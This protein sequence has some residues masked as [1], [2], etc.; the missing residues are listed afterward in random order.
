MA[1]GKGIPMSIATRPRRFP[2]PRLA[3][4]PALPAPLPPATIV[5]ARVRGDK[6]VD[7]MVVDDDDSIDWSDIKWTD[8]V[9]PVDDATAAK[10]MV[11]AARWREVQLRPPRPQRSDVK[12]LSE[13]VLEILAMKAA[14]LR[15]CSI[16][17]ITGIDRRQ[18][19]RVIRW[20]FD[21]HGVR[22]QELA[23]LPEKS[24]KGIREFLASRWVGR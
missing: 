24:P 5:T 2:L 18:I 15:V 19:D 3:P 1:H 23:E 4:M 22:M 14:D 6:I 13:V 9:R 11:A 12:C 16:Q 21:C 20:T 8:N 10:I 7:I 17:A